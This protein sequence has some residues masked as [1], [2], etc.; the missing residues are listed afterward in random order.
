MIKKTALVVGILAGVVLA[1]LGCVY[2][3]QDLTA[4]MSGPRGQGRVY[5]RI[6]LVILSLLLVISCARRLAKTKRN[7]NNAE[8]PASEEDA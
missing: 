8:Q 5:G 6:A 1:I 4:G 7:R 2:L 3:L